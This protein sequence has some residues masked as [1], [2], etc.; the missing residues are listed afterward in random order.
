MFYPSSIDKKRYFPNLSK[1][2]VIPLDE[3][4]EDDTE[5]ETETI[6][7]H[8]KNSQEEEPIK[9][10][11]QCTK[12]TENGHIEGKDK[13]KETAEDVVNIHIEE[14]EFTDEEAEKEKYGDEDGSVEER[15]LSDEEKCEKAWDWD[16]TLDEI[17]NF[18]HPV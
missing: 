15:G 11:T 6:P 14:R 5:E 8:L 17:K 3:D 12:E 18:L 16:S 4:T 1:K 10:D 13:A 7:K 9:N 2:I